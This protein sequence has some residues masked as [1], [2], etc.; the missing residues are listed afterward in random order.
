MSLSIK[1]LEE[2]DAK[3]VSDYLSDYGLEAA[4]IRWKYFDDEFNQGRNR[5]YVALKENRPVGF[6]GLIPFTASDRGR[7]IE[8]AWTCDWSVAGDES[9]R[10]LGVAVLQK[11]LRAFPSVFHVGGNHLTRRVFDRLANTVNADGVLDYVL[12]LRLSAV[13]HKAA[14]RVRFLKH[15]NRT[16]VA[17]LPVRRVGRVRADDGVEVTAGLDERFVEVTSRRPGAPTFFP[18][19]DSSYIDW[20][21]GRCPVL[22][23]YSFVG[24]GGAAALAWH[25][26]RNGREWRFAISASSSEADDRRAVLGSVI[27]FAYANGADTLRATAAKS[28]SETRALLSEAAFLLNGYRPFYAFHAAQDRH[29]YDEPWGLSFLDCDEATIRLR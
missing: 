7:L 11:A 27:R 24:R 26:A 10:T 15:L 9:N 3:A 17:R 22:D 8:T 14:R 21:I 4:V 29:A 13:I 2:V 6:I 25:L 12:P 18:V 19:Y 23:S 1:R 5:G 20:Q 16:P 28:D